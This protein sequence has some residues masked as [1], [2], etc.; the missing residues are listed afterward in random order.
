MDITNI[1]DMWK[2][3]ETVFKKN[4]VTLLYQT[5]NFPVEITL[6]ND[7]SVS[8]KISSDIK[9]KFIFL[10]ASIGDKIFI[11]SLEQ[12]SKEKGMSILKPIRINVKDA[13]AESKFSEQKIF[14]TNII[15]QNDIYKILNDDSIQKIVKDNSVRLKHIFDF[16]SINITE[17]QDNRTRLMLAAE[18]PIFVPDKTETVD[19]PGFVPFSEYYAATK[20]DKEAAKYRS[21][22]CIPVRYRESINIG[23][24][25]VQHSKKTD[26]NSFNL[27]NL[28]ASSLKKEISDYSSFEESRELCRVAHLSTTNI[29]FFHLPTRLYSKVFFLGAS[30]LFDIYYNN[31][32]KKITMRATVSSLQATEKHYKVDCT[33]SNL[34]MKQFEF[35]EEFTAKLE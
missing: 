20:K 17:R 7:Y 29:T 13:N 34:S 30:I 9:D 16:F 8:C 12:M 35:L 32:E 6:L 23:Y 26:L 11:C 3:M 15:N 4:P 24:V 31:N 22:I 21:E 14:V 5:Q 1:E 18:R 10:S 33:F 28:I 2:I 25:L 19:S 27:V